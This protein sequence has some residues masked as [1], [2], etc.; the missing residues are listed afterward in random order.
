MLKPS[1]I[2]FSDC[3]QVPVKKAVTSI[4]GQCAALV[5]AMALAAFPTFAFVLLVQM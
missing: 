1:S 4:A 5:H 3:E 2:F